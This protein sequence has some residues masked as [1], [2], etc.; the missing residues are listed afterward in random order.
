MCKP[1]DNKIIPP[2]PIVKENKPE[3][4][5]TFSGCFT[6]PVA[7]K[8][9]DRIFNAKKKEKEF[10]AEQEQRK[11]KIRRNNKAYRDCI[12]N[13]FEEQGKI[14]RVPKITEKPVNDNFRVLS[15]EAKKNLDE[16]YYYENNL[17]QW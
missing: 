2:E 7:E 6:R 10:N 16:R 8:T 17:D 15:S 13:M 11:G 14:S 3:L 4:T 5:R 9:Y 12:G 1:K